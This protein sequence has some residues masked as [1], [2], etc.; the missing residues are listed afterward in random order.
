MM[1]SSCMMH[2]VNFLRNS[3]LTA[4]GISHRQPLEAHCSR[5]PSC[6]R[7]QYCH[8]RIPVSYAVRAPRNLIR[9]SCFMPYL[10]LDLHQN[11]CVHHTW[12][13]NAIPRLV[14]GGRNKYFVQH[15]DSDKELA[16]IILAFVMRGPSVE[17]VARRGFLCSW[18]LF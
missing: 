12:S 10:P 13:C 15:W 3:L 18:G 2:M 1:H 11:S 9:G 4:A 17:D 8:R 16:L 7:Y 6:R 14:A 5:S